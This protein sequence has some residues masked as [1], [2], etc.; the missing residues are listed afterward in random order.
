MI[1]SAPV[2]WNSLSA[3][4]RSPLISRV[5]FWAGLKTHLFRLFKQ[6][7]SLWERNELNWTQ[8]VSVRDR[9]T[10]ATRRP[11][12]SSGLKTV[13]SAPTR[14]SCRT[15][16]RWRS[17]CRYFSSASSTPSWWSE[18]VLWDWFSALRAEERP[19]AE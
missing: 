12:R 5:Q 4:L 2:V 18:Y 19:G 17:R 3:H 9:L 14:R 13:S 10:T 16:S 8:L 7:H 15:R 1:G 6:A 11:A